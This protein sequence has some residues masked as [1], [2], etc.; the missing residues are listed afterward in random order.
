LETPFTKKCE[1]KNWKLFLAD[2]R[3]LLPTLEPESFDAVITDPP[4]NSGGLTLR[5]RSKPSTQ[6]YVSSGSKY[7][8]APEIAFDGIPETEWEQLLL[9]VFRQS[10]R[11]LKPG[12]L[13][14]VFTDWRRLEKMASILSL[15]GIPPKGV[16]VWNKTAGSRPVKGGFNLQTEFILWGRKGS[17]APE[18]YAQGVVTAAPLTK[19]QHITQKP[20]KV[21]EHLLKV[22][23][24]GGKVLDPFAGVATTGVAC[25]K[26]GYSFTGVEVVP[27]YFE[28]G[29]RRLKELENN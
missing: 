15:T 29:C 23:P 9:T 6:K 16:V 19:K 7:Q 22:V 4:Y 27:E 5:H 24:K 25:L 1:G 2:S 8:N 3:F 10:I 18:L 21:I 17:G 20:V 12:G 26:N 28:I 11:L 13:I 14:V